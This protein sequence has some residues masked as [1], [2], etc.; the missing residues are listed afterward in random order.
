MS[1]HAEK[2]LDFSTVIAADDASG[3]MIPMP[4]VGLLRPRRQAAAVGGGGEVAGEEEEMEETWDLPH[5]A[6]L[7]FAW[8]HVYVATPDQM[9]TVED[10]AYAYL[11]KYR[12]KLQPDG[13]MKGTPLRLDLPPEVSARLAAEKE[14][15]DRESRLAVFQPL[16]PQELEAR[17]AEAEESR[18]A[19]EQEER[20]TLDDTSDIPEVD[21]AEDD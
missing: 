16:S 8:N 15:E 1:D 3:M 10:L 9:E 4:V 17:R 7:V 21:Q 5:D 11:L 2:Q 12:Y 13:S 20:E 6:H 14:R 19:L 18:R